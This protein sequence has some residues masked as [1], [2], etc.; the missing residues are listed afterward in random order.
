VERYLDGLAQPHLISDNTSS[1]LLMQLGKP[2]HRSFLKREE[3]L[4]EKPRCDKVTSE[5]NLSDRIC[6][7]GWVHP[8][9]AWSWSEI[10]EDGFV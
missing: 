4:V 7:R 9:I 5:W 1:A 3:L 8:N 10:K 2:L 6:V